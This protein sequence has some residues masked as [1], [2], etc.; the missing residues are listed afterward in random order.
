VTVPARFWLRAGLAFLA[1][2]EVAIGARAVPA[3]AAR[4][5]VGQAVRAAYLRIG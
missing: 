3:N 4:P 1:V 2:P 5:A